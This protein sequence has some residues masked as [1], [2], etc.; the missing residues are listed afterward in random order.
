MK[1]TIVSLCFLMST[2]RIHAVH[3][4]I[5]VIANK[6]VTIDNLGKSDVRRIFKGK[7]LEWDDGNKIKVILFT[8]NP[9]HKIFCKYYLKNS[10]V[11]LKNSLKNMIITGQIMGNHVKRFN[12]AKE[13]IQFINQN[14]N[15]ISYLPSDQTADLPENIKIIPIVG[16]N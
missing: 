8:K 4:P 1:W 14:P 3:S 7:I 11:Q 2:Q 6:S 12:D 10:P 15:S 5:N 16:V 13:V 9:V